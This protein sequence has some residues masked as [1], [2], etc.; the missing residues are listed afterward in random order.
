M[1]IIKLLSKSI[2]GPFK[3]IWTYSNSNSDNLELEAPTTTYFFFIYFLRPSL[4]VAL[5][6]LNQTLAHSMKCKRLQRLKEV[7]L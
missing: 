7:L 3:V 6:T 2:P 4:N 5:L 1:T